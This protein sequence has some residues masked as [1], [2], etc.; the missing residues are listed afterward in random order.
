MGHLLSEQPLGSGLAVSEPYQN[1]IQLARFGLFAE[2]KQT[3]QIVEKPRNS[4]NLREGL[5]AVT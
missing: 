5:D 2:R 3:P 1:P 4:I